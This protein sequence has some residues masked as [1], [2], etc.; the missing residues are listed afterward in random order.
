[1]SLQQL[2]LDSII[3]SR[4]TR[5]KEGSASDNANLG[6]LS[7]WVLVG[8]VVLKSDLTKSVVVVCLELARHDSVDDLRA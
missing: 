5:G 8:L 1:M 4:E 6:V 3:Y 2:G 7:S